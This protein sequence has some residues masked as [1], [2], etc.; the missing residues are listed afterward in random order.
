MLSNK[1]N[2]LANLLY[3]W[4]LIAPHRRAPVGIVFELKEFQNYAKHFTGASYNIQEIHEA[5][6][7]LSSM[8]LLNLIDGWPRE[9]RK[10]L[11]QLVD[12]E[13]LLNSSKEIGLLWQ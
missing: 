6:H 9:Y 8:K 3:D 5:A 11:L 2:A 7:L 13:R 4:T 1:L 12:Y 10:D